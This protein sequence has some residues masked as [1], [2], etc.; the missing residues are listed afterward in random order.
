MRPA[1]ATRHTAVYKYKIAVA[2]VPAPQVGGWGKPHLGTSVT[3]P[4]CPYELDQAPP[5]H[6]VALTDLSGSCVASLPV[7]STVV[8]RLIP[9]NDEKAPFCQRP[10]CHIVLDSCV[11]A[12]T[13][14]TSPLNRALSS[15]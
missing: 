7:P 13:T 11:L 2:R 3:A 9:Q 12:P 5:L 1:S 8:A 15:L 14:G 10:T 4:A 6:S